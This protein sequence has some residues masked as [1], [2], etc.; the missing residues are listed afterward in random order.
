MPQAPVVLD[1]LRGQRPAREEAAKRAPK[2][3]EVLPPGDG[4]VYR[5]KYEQYRHQITSPVKQLT[6][7]GV[8]H[9]EPA[10][11]AQFIGGMFR[12]SHKDPK[13]RKLIDERLQESPYF[14]LNGLF[15]LQSQQDERDRMKLAEQ[16]ARA[17]ATDPML[18]AEIERRVALRL[19][20]SEDLPNQPSA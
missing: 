10:L 4:L 1:G 9:Q 7:D 6:T 19:G 12:N 15:W 13:K 5:S 3:A 17:I 2:A 16:T 11:V 18:E 20:K 14:G 8:F